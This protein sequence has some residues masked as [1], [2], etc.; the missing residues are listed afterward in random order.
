VGFWAEGSS[1]GGEGTSDNEGKIDDLTIGLAA[2]EFS[3]LVFKQTLAGRIDGLP[4]CRQSFGLQ[5]S[6]KP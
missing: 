5:P 1:H 6:S 3:T 2:I 4:A